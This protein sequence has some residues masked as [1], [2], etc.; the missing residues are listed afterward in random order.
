MKT[1]TTATVNQGQL[2]L[3]EPLDLPDQSRVQVTIELN[4]EWRSRY[5]AGLERF[6]KL[7]RERPINAGVRF[8]REELHE[9]G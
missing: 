7:I 6:K 5:R 9:R 1:Q 4:E 2:E 3:D 8:T